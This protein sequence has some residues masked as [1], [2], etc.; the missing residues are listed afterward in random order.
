[1]DVDPQ[2]CRAIA[3]FAIR[4]PRADLSVDATVERQVPLRVLLLRPHLVAIGKHVV[5]AVGQGFCQ[6]RQ[7][8]DAMR[9]RE[10]AGPA[11]C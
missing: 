11:N 7:R 8:C 9:K 3:A 4:C 6:S 5:V 2:Y 1:M 10:L